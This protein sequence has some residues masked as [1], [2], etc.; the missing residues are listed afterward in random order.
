[1][2]EAETQ[3]TFKTCSF[4]TSWQNSKTVNLI[5]GTSNRVVKQNDYLM[6]I[7]KVRKIGYKETSLLG[8]KAYE[9]FVLWIR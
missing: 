8:N 3:T 7:L 9:T 6:A 5:T 4:S 2:R 1:M